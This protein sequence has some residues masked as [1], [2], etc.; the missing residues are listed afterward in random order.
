[1]AG[2]NETLRRG[3]E[4][5]DAGAFEDAARVLRTA[6]QR[7][8]EVADGWHLRGV[9]E[10]RRGDL[11]AARAWIERAIALDPEVAA[12]HVNLGNVRRAAGEIGAA[13]ASFER[14][15]ALEPED[16]RVLCNL[17]NALG[18]AGELAAATDAY[19]RAA[20][21]DAGLGDAYQGLAWALTAAGRI[22]EIDAVH[23]AWAR[24]APDDPAA[25]W[26]AGTDRTTAAVAGYFDRFASTYD[27]VL[28]AI[29][30]RVPEELAA[31]LPAPDGTWSVLD[32]GSGSGRCGSILRPW[33]RSLCGA[34]VSGAM[35]SVAAATGAY[36][37]LVHGDAAALLRDRTFDLV[38]AADVLPYMEDPSPLLGGARLVAFSVELASGSDV[39]RRPSA[40]Y[41]HGEAFVHALLHRAGLHLVAQRRRTLRREAGQ[42]VEGLLVVASRMGG[43]S[44][45]PRGPADDR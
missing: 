44:L 24:A 7:W 10:Y 30:Y 34:D 3:V 26:L 21:A 15:L 35:L 45:Q 33:A 18:D 12:Y 43:D 27:A 6:T 22:E 2:A 16:A 23:R 39:E 25:R 28:D 38:F 20:A 13:I 9:A 41:A 14:A 8:P 37:E 40:R 36:D 5:I 19:R 32:A 1:M 17:G 4:L 42:P 31:L 11:D 29:D